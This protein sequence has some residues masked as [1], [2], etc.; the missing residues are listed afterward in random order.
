MEINLTQEAREELR[1]RH[2]ACRDKR[3]CDRIK[4]I[5][6]YDEGHSYA[7]ICRWLLLDDETIRRY[8]SD[9]CYDKKVH[10]LSGGSES[11]LSEEEAEEL[12][13]H[14]EEKTYK[15]VESICHYVK[16]R[17]GILYTVSGMTKWLHAHNFCYKKPH[18]VPAKANREEQ[19]KFIEAYEQLKVEAAEKGFPIYF[20]DSVHP[21]NQTRLAYGWI[22]KGERKGIATTGRQPRMNIMGGICLDNHKIV[23]KEAEKINEDSIAA[24]LQKLRNEHKD[25]EK[26]HVIWDNAGYHSSEFVKEF[27][28]HIGIILHYLPPFV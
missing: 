27:A 11:K 12:I 28:E 8:I 15:D 26:V 6:A 2:K 23:Y 17:Y 10:S 20:V 9:Y 5:L 16:K 21:E 3:T 4:A 22:R 18:P 19:E 24:F 1:N 25:I 7:E 13:A 14:L